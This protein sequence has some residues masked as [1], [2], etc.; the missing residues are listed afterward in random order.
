MKINFVGKKIDSSLKTLI[1][2]AVKLTLQ[3][4]KQENKNLEL[5]IDFVD[6]NEMQELNNRTRAINSVTDVLSFPNFELKPFENIECGGE[7]VLL[8][9]M[10]I[11]MS[12]A[13]EQAKEY[14]NSREKE[15]VKLVVHSVLHLMGFDHIKDGDFKIMN[16]EEEK[17]ASEFWAN[18]E[19]C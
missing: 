2:D 15:I 11:C 10:A 17:I 5:N 7:A 4:L 12:R 13:E 1:K 6:E 19:I 14:G 3:D 16:K 18:H 9:D 8:G